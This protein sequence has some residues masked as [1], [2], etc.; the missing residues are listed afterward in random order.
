MPNHQRFISFIFSLFIAVFTFAQ[1]PNEENGILSVKIDSTYFPFQ[2]TSPNLPNKLVNLTKMVNYVYGVYKE[3]KPTGLILTVSVNYKE[4]P[5]SIQINYRE[6]ELIDN[7]LYLSFE[8]MLNGLG[9]VLSDLSKKYSMKYMDEIFLCPLD[10]GEASIDICRKYEKCIRINKYNG[11]LLSKV[12]NESMLLRC[13]KEKI[14]PFGKEIKTFSFEKV[15]YITTDAY[16][17]HY[18][19]QG[20]INNLPKRFYYPHDFQISLCNIE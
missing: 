20:N 13:I 14:L 9:S 16:I 1:T 15:S 5:V 2:S 18:N 10:F 7:N 12:Y 4:F 6:K 17:L 19:Y 8:E 11:D 3:G